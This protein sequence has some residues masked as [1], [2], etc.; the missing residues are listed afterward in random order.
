MWFLSS[1]TI[2][3]TNWKP[4]LIHKFFF[5]WLFWYKICSNGEFREFVYKPLEPANSLETNCVLPRK[6]NFSQ[7]GPNFD[8]KSLSF[9]TAKRRKRTTGQNNCRK[10]IYGLW[11][12]LEKLYLWNDFEHYLFTYSV[13][14]SIN[15]N[16]SYLHI[17]C[18]KLF[19]FNFKKPFKGQILTGKVSVSR[20]WIQP[21]H[22]KQTVFYLEKPISAKKGQILTVKVS[23][24]RPPK[25]ARGLLVKITVE[26][27]SMV[28][29]M[30]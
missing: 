30:A 3:S 7:K 15:Y 26:N 14:I 21:T 2:K 22:W 18:P 4:P 25:D 6:A 28:Y 5:R 11:Y 12:G 23:V 17:P 8:W 19:I 24:S 27:Q 13:W 16:Y 29:D 1:V 20:P 9:E 10:S